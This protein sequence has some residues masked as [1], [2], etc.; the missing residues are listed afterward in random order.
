MEALRHFPQVVSRHLLRMVAG[1]PVPIGI[2]G[3]PLLVAGLALGVAI[4]RSEV[5]RGRSVRA[6]VFFVAIWTALGIAPALVAGYESP[7]H[8]YLAS[9]GW[10]IGLG[11]VVDVLWHTR[12][13][14]MM[15]AVTAVMAAL[16]VAAYGVQLGASVQDWN[17]RAAVSR[18]AVMDLERE[19][20]AVPEGSLLIVGVSPRSWEWALPF[21]ARPPFASVDLPRRV[22]VI[23]PVALH[24]CRV[25]WDEDTRQ[26]LAAW[27]RQPDSRNRSSRS[28]G[29]TA[30]VL[31]HASPTARSRSCEPSSSPGWRP[32]VP[33]RSREW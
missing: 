15:R 30:R 14:R 26:T 22:H 29:M 17:V 19:A 10:V 5:D 6:G 12:P 16:L 33:R 21:A 23:S 11:L 2:I 13:R 20:L 27:F 3:V 9:V 7:R 25:R 32:A 28:T 1:R 4:F 31:C 8:I 18:Q 24:C